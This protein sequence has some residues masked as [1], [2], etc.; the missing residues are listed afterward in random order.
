M[1]LL[2]E[3]LN[4]ISKLS[5]ARRLR[6]LN[7]LEAL[8]SYMD[9]TQLRNELLRLCARPRSTGRLKGHLAT[10]DDSL[11]HALAIAVRLFRRHPCDLPAGSYAYDEEREA[12][13]L[14]VAGM[15]VQMDTGE[16]KTYV[17]ALAAVALLC[18][19]PQILVIT[20]NP[21]LAHRDQAR[22]APFITAAGFSCISE[23]PDPAFRGVAY[24]TLTDLCH[25]YLRRTYDYP[26]LVSAEYPDEAAII[27]DEIDSVLI[28]H[29]P[30][31]SL[32]FS[33]PG[34]DG[35][36][37]DVFGLITNWN[38]EQFSYE[39]V[40]ER[41]SLTADA[42][43]RVSALAGATKRPV[44]LL[45]DLVSGAL[46]ARGATE[47]RQYQLNGTTIRMIDSVTG[48][49]YWSDSARARALEHLL[50]KTNPPVSLTIADL[51][52]PSLIKRHPLAV[53]LS[54]TAQ[55]E[56]LYFLQQL[57]TLTGRVAPKFKRV[58]GR[59]ESTL[60][61]SRQATL[62]HIGSRI[63]EVSPRPVVIGTW[64][65]QEA[66]AIA[67]YLLAG[68]VPS[69]YLGLITRFDSQADGHLI[70]VAGHLHR[71]T[72]LNQGGSRGV[73][74]RST[75]RPLLIVVGKAVEPR[76]D[77]QFLGRVGRHGEPFDA[78]FVI[79]PSS[80]IWFSPMGLA[81]NMAD[82]AFPIGKFVER[83]LRRLQRQAWAERIRRRHG[84]TMLSDA[85]SAVELAVAKKFNRLRQ[86]DPQHL[87]ALISELIS[88]PVAKQE[89]G[90]FAD[91]DARTAKEVA[92]DVAAA[93]WRRTESDSLVCRFEQSL[94][95]VCPELDSAPQGGYAYRRAVRGDP[96]ELRALVD[97]L[98]HEHSSDHSSGEGLLLRRHAKSAALQFLPVTTTPHS[99]APRDVIFETFRMTNALLLEETR[100][101]LEALSVSS[102]GNLYYRRGV[103]AI[104]NLYDMAQSI[105][106]RE[107]ASNLCRVDHPE[108]LDELFYST[109]HAIRAS[110]QAVDSQPTSP[111]SSEQTAPSAGLGV[112]R[113]EEAISEFLDDREEHAALSVSREQARV[114]LLGL[115]QPLLSVATP[116][117]SE[118]FS[119]H[120]NLF[121]ESLAAKGTRGLA[122][123]DNQRLIND[124]SEFLWL[125]GLLPFRPVRAGL[126]AAAVRR[127]R[128]FAGTIPRVGLLALIGQL[129]LILLGIIVSISSARQFQSI[130]MISGV[131]GFGYVFPHRPLMQLFGC[132]MFVYSILRA[133]GL[134]DSTDSLGLLAM[135]GGL[136]V[137][138]MLYVRGV[139]NVGLPVVIALALV[140]WS[141]ALFA[142][143]RLVAALVGIDMNLFIAGVSA[144]SFAVVFLP[145]HPLVGAPLLTGVLAAILSGPRVPVSLGS[146]ETPRGQV[147]SIEDIS[148][149]RVA[150][151][152]G[153]SAAVAAL[154]ATAAT[155]GVHGDLPAVTFA[156]VQSAVFSVLTVR[157]LRLASVEKMLATLHVGSQLE[158]KELGA[159]LRNAA[160]L[161]IALGT[162]AS[163]FSIALAWHH[164]VSS[165]WGLVTTELGGV[166]IVGAL[167]ASSNAIRVAGTASPFS[168]IDQR[169]SGVTA[170]R[171]R[172]RSWRRARFARIVEAVVGGAVLIRPVVWL[173]DLVGRI[174]AIHQLWEMIRRL[175]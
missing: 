103:Y 125:S 132:L 154:A 10:R 99:R 120:V 137:A 142:T 101:R 157:R 117:T 2:A 138:A 116:L 161:Y 33:L 133:F 134:V 90:R 19:F 55:D 21:Y 80:P 72:V 47:G 96:R 104:R 166:T 127:L 156:L 25:T 3:F 146:T 39:T 41:V 171:E 167:L 164:G 83:S 162:L 97:W 11:I 23:V 76:L 12:A 151:D 152:P 43:E 22:V 71:V 35:I 107:L 94:I 24:V 140:I 40:S 63:R 88:Q 135:V 51:D 128:R 48:E 89:D 17:V 124:F 6:D 9:E 129:L 98:E 77:K 105:E 49:E 56:S 26:A 31:Y 102:P 175:R 165:L 37:R 60:S 20:P 1:S 79:D 110:D 15:N 58:H 54:G 136:V 78:E 153:L 7:E 145:H 29:N 119:H 126:V 14:L 170:I 81:T 16:G 45:L 113:L 52:A 36:W 122:L 100:R 53:G 174:D 4:T 18:E 46:W 149:V 168:S 150:I 74:V 141:G 38:E 5:S 172:A 106:T 109:E 28:D 144:V 82:G 148:R 8:Y 118:A 62:E 158:L 155:F 115:A 123:R 169:S 121:I 160:P 42:W 66:D 131:F 112:E 159:R 91:L 173:A 69:E 84:R 93:M 70:Q 59:I 111:L 75:E 114:L 30:N 139:S 27:V 57:G 163:S 64:S 68:I 85:T 147:A 108:L 34:D 143:Q 130:D 67:K 44:S 50:F 32:V 65:A 86:V 61:P 87:E 13:L 92:D 73:D 95:D